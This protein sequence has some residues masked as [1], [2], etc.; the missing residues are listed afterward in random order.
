MDLEY[1]EQLVYD[2]KQKNINTKEEIIKLFSPFILNLA[3]KTYING[4]TFEDIRNECY[5]SLLYALNKYEVGN[6]SFAKYAFTA[7]RN[8]L[9]DLIRRRISHYESDGQCA[10]TL[11]DNL[12]YILVSED[13][14]LYET[15]YKN[16]CFN[17]L[18]NIISTLDKDEKEFISYIYIKNNP[19][20]SYAEFKNINYYQARYIQKKL[21][22][23]LNQKFAEKHIYS[24]D[25]L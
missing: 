16:I 9:N 24:I 3:G 8:N 2:L 10:L 11:T 1:V 6:N 23:K 7:I 25:E 4:Y 12:E 18:K 20:T 13:K 21:L 14:P 22:K 19:L 17:T 5:K 15:A